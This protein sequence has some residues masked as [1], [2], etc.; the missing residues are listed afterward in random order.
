MAPDTTVQGTGDRALLKMETL[1]TFEE[2]LVG[3]GC[4]A[5]DKK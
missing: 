5:G 2:L 1:A 4:Q 3:G